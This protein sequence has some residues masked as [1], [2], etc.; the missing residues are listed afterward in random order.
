VDIVVDSLFVRLV[1]YWGLYRAA[2]VSGFGWIGPR[3]CVF[4]TGI[5]R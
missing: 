5:P 1:R 3:R 2:R 4:A